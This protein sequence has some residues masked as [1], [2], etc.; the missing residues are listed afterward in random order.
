MDWDKVL[1]VLSAADHLPGPSYRW[2]RRRGYRRFYLEGP[3]QR[4]RIE[5]GEAWYAWME[6][7]TP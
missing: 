5:S 4:V 7:K 6:G 3:L 1:D 2:K